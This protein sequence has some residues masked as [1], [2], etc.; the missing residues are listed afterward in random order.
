MEFTII[1]ILLALILGAVLIFYLTHKIL[2]VISF[3]T[4]FVVLAFLIIGAFVIV[5]AKNFQDKMQEENNLFIITSNDNPVALIPMGKEQELTSEQESKIMNELSDK[6]SY[7]KLS[8]DYFKLF[9]VKIKI[10]DSIKQDKFEIENFNF[11]KQQISDAIIAKNPFPVLGIN[12][13]LVPKELTAS[14][15]KMALFMSTIQE[16]ITSNPIFLLKEYKKGN[17]YVYKETI[18]FKVIKYIPIS[19]VKSIV[20]KAKNKIKLGEDNGNI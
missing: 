18:M 1:G 8:Q 12:E 13:N 6:S 7:Q 19:F 15:L 11:T 5:D 3:V 17:I 16:Q 10:L 14:K 9:F 20:N 2:K 4:G